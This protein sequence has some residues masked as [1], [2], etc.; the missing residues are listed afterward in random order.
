MDQKL[1]KLSP[2]WKHSVILI[3]I[4]GFSLLIFVAVKSY[5]DAPPIPE[6][7]VDP[8]GKV[9]FTSS[10]IKAG[11]EIFL[12]HGLMEHGTLLGHGA[13]LGPDYSAEYLHREAVTIQNELA[14]ERYNKPY[15]DLND[16]EKNS[17]VADVQA[18]L[19]TNRY[20]ATTGVLKFTAQE[21]DAFQNEIQHWTNYFTKS[22][23]APG[24]PEGF[25][26]DP[27]ELKQ[28]TSFFAWAAWSSVSNRPGKNYSY[29]NNWP[30]DT[31]AGNTPTSSAVIWSA[32][33][34]VSLLGM[35]GLI[36]FLFGKFDYLG[37]KSGMS[38]HFENTKAVPPTETQK[39]LLKYFVVISILFVIQTFAGGALAHY[40]VEPFGFYGLNIEKFL[41]FNVLRTWH[42]QLAIFWIA[43]SYVA[44]GLFL[45]P[46]LS[47]TEP[48]GQKFWTN[49]L[50]AA[51]VIVALGS[52][53]GEF[54]GINQFFGKLW[55]YLG[56]QGW[57]Y[58]D[59]GRIW[60]ILL[61]VG[62]IIWLILVF[63]S[64]RPSMKE[65]SQRELSSL[66]L[67]S[68]IAIPLFYLP[69]LFFGPSTNFTV[70]DNW[71]F[72]IIHL[73]VEGF[74]EL[75]ATVMVAV[76]FYQL[77]LVSSLSASRVVYLDA[78]LYL[79]SGIVGTGHHWYWTGQSN[80]TMAL[81]AMFSAMEVVPLTLL[82]LDAWDF[83]RLTR[84]SNPE[85][86][87]GIADKQKWAFYFLMA[88]GFWNFLGAGVFGFL[89]NLPIVSYYEVG[90]SLT[91]NHGHAAMMG[92][93]GM[94]ALGIMMY[95]LRRLSTDNV[96]NQNEKFIRTGFW[97]LNIGLMLM[98]VL[99]LFPAGV[100]QLADVV[101]N[102]YW[103]A[104]TL[105]FLDSGTFHLLE[106]FRIVAD[107]IFIF[108]GSIP[109]CIFVLKIFAA[110]KKMWESPAIG[111]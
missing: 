111:A 39:A 14:S 86:T 50:F 64:I 73:W 54:L 103:H 47:K 60:Q 102:G 94:L 110:R 84:K 95:A 76:I 75:F 55:Y 2:W 79:G 5:R 71:R 70:V 41:P 69:A 8:Q 26:S 32:L 48:E 80:I 34:L 7:V 46:L 92:V 65:Q 98:V 18:M 1:Q 12:K 31:L 43:M 101:N 49:V 100:L 89:I 68:A 85:T 15:S 96:W 93:F 3:M 87:A 37:W 51:V 58:L 59:L 97:G 24:L 109:I 16:E 108:A 63:R 45:P 10:D 74:F 38:D 107:L 40:R 105:S 78:I 67:Y 82:T 61:I 23:R 56:M 106:W 33:S 104:R 6:K 9:I 62:L 44:G 77:G 57:E 21:A 17:I 35:T 83:I 99:D 11:Q 30:F 22:D 4:V 88:V 13:Y 27:Q 72:W 19:H 91:L 28:L 81:G 20:D 66:F 36:L 25:I 42:L 90:T 53:L 52:L 29:T